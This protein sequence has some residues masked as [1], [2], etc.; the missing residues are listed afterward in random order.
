MFSRTVLT[1][2]KSPAKASS[3]WKRPDGYFQASEENVELRGQFP[4]AG[5]GDQ[6]PGN[7]RCAIQITK[8]SPLQLI[9]WRAT[10]RPRSGWTAKFLTIFKR[11]QIQ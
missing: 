2:E 10:R 9:H 1:G 8:W 5:P 11:I 4:V 7:D 3:G 6:S